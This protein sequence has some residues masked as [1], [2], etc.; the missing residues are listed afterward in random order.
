MGKFLRKLRKQKKMSLEQL[1]FEFEKEFLTVSPNAISNWENGKTI[2]E[3]NNLNFLSL[4]YEVSIDEILDG[5]KH[6]NIDFETKYF[7][8]KPLSSFFDSFNESSKIR[9]EFAKQAIGIKKRAK[10]LIFKYI[11]EDSSKTEIDELV[12]LLKNYYNLNPNLSIRTFLQKLA[13]LRN[14]GMQKND[15]WWIIQRDIRPID[16]LNVSFSDISDECFKFKT[17]D[18]AVDSLESWEKD[19][20]LALIQRKDPI[21]LDPTKYN[22]KAIIRYREDHQK[23]FNPEQ[24]IKETIRYLIEKGACINTAYFGYYKTIEEEVRPI[25]EFEDMFNN[26]KKPISL[27]VEEKGERKY[28]KAEHNYRNHVLINYRYSIVKPLVELGYSYDEIIQLLIKNKEIPDEVYL[29]ASKKKGIDINRDFALI[30][31]DVQWDYM[32]MQ[33]QWEKCREEQLAYPNKNDSLP[34]ELDVLRDDVLSNN[35]SMKRMNLCWVGGQELNEAEE[36]ILSKNQELSFS[37]YKVCRDY[38]KTKELLNSL[39][40]LGLEEIKEQYFEL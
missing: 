37:D 12:F 32:F 6:E 1:S 38:N 3:I 26:F 8:H 15:L 13:D 31:A 18:M 10:D 25:E 20:L 39:D 29:R 2:P 11:N 23:D 36:Y 7:L 30:K 24:I 28:Y 9:I 5:E 21:F 35:A 17:V 4:F 22:S 19:M 16:R 40:K 34:V 14:Y 27:V 33:N